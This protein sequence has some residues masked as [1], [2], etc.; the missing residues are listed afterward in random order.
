MGPTPPAHFSY[1]FVVWYTCMRCVSKYMHGFQQQVVHV[2]SARPHAAQDKERKP[3]SPGG[4]ASSVQSLDLGKPRN[5]HPQRTKFDLDTPNAS[6]CMQLLCNV[7][8]TCVNAST[9][10]HTAACC[11]PSITMRLIFCLPHRGYLSRIVPPIPQTTCHFFFCTRPIS[12]SL[13]T[14]LTFTALY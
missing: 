3:C 14:W 6:P 8:N 7:H 9:D 5:G 2:V 4:C 12:L 11:T 1:I 10:A 13:N